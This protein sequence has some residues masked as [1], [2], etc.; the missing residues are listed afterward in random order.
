[1]E[2]ESYYRGGTG[3]RS[4]ADSRMRSSEMGEPMRAPIDLKASPL[5]IQALMNV[6]QEW[7]IQWVS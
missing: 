6:L 4:R 3:T 5:T 1:M 2:A 7:G